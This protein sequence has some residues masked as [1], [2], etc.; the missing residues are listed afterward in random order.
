VFTKTGR[1]SSQVIK[2]FE[3]NG[4]TLG[5]VVHKMDRYVRFAIGTKE[6]MKEF[7]RVWDTLPSMSHKIAL[8]LIGYKVAG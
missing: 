4:I 2:H 7:W 1:P 3:R 8:N 6:N 5:P